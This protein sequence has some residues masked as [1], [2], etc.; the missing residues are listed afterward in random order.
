MEGYLKRAW[1]LSIITVTLTFALNLHEAERLALENFYG[2][3]AKDLEVK[4]A[5]TE[6]KEKFS[7]FLPVIN[8]EASYNIAREQSF[9]FGAPP[10]IPPQ[11]FVFLKDQ[12]PKVTLTFSQNLL[13]LPAFREY[14][15]SKTK[16][17]ASKMILEEEKIKTLY[18]VREAYIN[19]LKAKAAIQILE[20]Q[21]E[22]V[23]AHLNDIKAL[24]EEGMVTLKDVLQTQV[25]LHE[26]LEKIAQARGN[27]RK[28]LDYLSYLTG[29][30]VEEIEELDPESFMA[31]EEDFEILREKVKNRPIL[32]YLD[33][34]LEIARESEDLVKSYF[35]PSLVFEA[36][37]QR[38]EES[39]LF[40]K[41]RFLISL[42]LRWNLFSGLK[43]FRNLEKAR[44]GRK[45]SLILKRD[46]EEKILLELRSVLEDIKTVRERIRLA[47]KQVESAKEHLKI[48]KERYLQGIGTN[49]EVLD[50]QSELTSAEENLRMS[51]Y[52]LVLYSFK[53]KE[54]VGDE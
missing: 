31:R 47:R 11:E 27:H 23:R 18:K 40:P 41:D 17:K 1:A 51:L 14:S 38:T 19:A 42:A 29:T 43:R 54:V 45:K 39:D 13:N 10:L 8:L 30:E 22:R 37:Y 16:E 9:A 21:E 35:Y 26:V 44:I 25:R 20:K 6:R 53:L 4:E 49:T 3:R 15:L 5:T 28:A 7:A 46:L 52:D 24:Y 12:F 36:F 48:A 2:I 32:R 34:G 50:A 33:A